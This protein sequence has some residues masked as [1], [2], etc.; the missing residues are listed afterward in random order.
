MHITADTETGE[1][2]DD[3]TEAQLAALIAALGRSSG[4]FIT[5]N[6]A[7]ETQ[8]WYASVSLL[9]DGQIEIEQTDP[10]HSENHH[11]ITTDSAA[12]IARNLSNWLA[13]RQ[14]ATDF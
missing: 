5:F 12:S 8:A 4:S 14:P 13:S 6:P 2:I 1:F 9:P 11:A 7:D 10:D 3:P